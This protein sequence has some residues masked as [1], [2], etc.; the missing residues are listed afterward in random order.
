MGMAPQ[1]SPLALARQN[2]SRLTSSLP[3]PLLWPSP[4]VPAPGRLTCGPE[5]P[6]LVF[7]RQA[8]MVELRREFRSC[9]QR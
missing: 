4:R 6:V 8:R 2:P 7:N 3:Q 1:F 9:L 5:Y